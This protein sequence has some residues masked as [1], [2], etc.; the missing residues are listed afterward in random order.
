MTDALPAP[1]L[2]RTRPRGLALALAVSLAVHALV[3]ALEFGASGR[4]LPWFQWGA[5]QRRVSLDELRVALRPAAPPADAIAPTPVLAPAPEVPTRPL[6]P[7]PHRI[8]P[9][10]RVL[11]QSVDIPA[12]PALETLVIE[13]P[14]LIP[15][16]AAP[17]PAPSRPPPRASAPLEPVAP[18]VITASEP[19]P[20]IPSPAPDPV[21]AAPPAPIPPPTVAEDEA[22][23][24]RADAAREKA[25]RQ[26]QEQA[27]QETQERV[28]LEKAALEKAA[29]EQ[30]A[31]DRALREDAER[32]AAQ[33]RAEQERLDAERREAERLAAERAEAT[34]VE[35][36]RA[37]A[38]RAM[39]E[40]AEAARLLA[41]RQAT[42]RALAEAPARG[43]DLARQAIDAIRAGRAATPPAP[44]PLPG[45]RR[46]SLFGNDRVDVQL[47]FY[48]DGWRQK[49]ERIGAMN[50]GGLKR[51][52]AYEP[53]QVTV[54]IQSDGALAAVAIHNTGAEPAMEQHIRRVLELAAPFAPF[55]PS[56][57]RQY[58]VIDIR[59]VWTWYDGRLL[60][61][62]D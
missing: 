19:T 23:A 49:L 34:R 35:A 54:S 31:R 18:V 32:K 45:G 17:A 22:D 3:L 52:R 8:R 7:R 9:D 44:T 24:V 51:N 39:A 59:R 28:A 12:A 21:S 43:A 37:D 36:A 60:I 10:A 38:A 20:A 16:T 40:R 14:K 5:Q 47:N 4:G 29:R 57:A 42:E 6:R 11:A 27:E 26:A 61:T 33:R 58:D 15:K 13:A 25:I 30:A 56:L 41:E 50:T 2:G 46:A 53:L 1:P 55:P 62:Q 48:G